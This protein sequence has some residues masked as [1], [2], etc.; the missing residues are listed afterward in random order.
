MR[1]MPPPRPRFAKKHMHQMN[2][3][4]EL[5]LHPKKM[6][7]NVL[8]TL[9]DIEMVMDKTFLQDPKECMWQSL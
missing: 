7:T 2:A 1:V 9:L 6:L 4:C 5:L 3:H 8:F